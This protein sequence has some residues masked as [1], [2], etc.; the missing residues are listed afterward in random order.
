MASSKK[1]SRIHG[2]IRDFEENFEEFLDLEAQAKNVAGDIEIVEPRRQ[3]LRTVVGY[4]N[5]QT[6]P[7]DD[8]SVH[9]FDRGHRGSNHNISEKTI[10]RDRRQ[11]TYTLVGYDPLQNES[12]VADDKNRKPSN[13]QD[14]V[15]MSSG[16]DRKT[17][18]SNRRLSNVIPFHNGHEC[19]YIVDDDDDNSRNKTPVD[20]DF[21]RDDMNMLKDDKE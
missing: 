5:T 9:S 8:K 16:S 19:D 14:V 11:S 2:V 6:K 12:K 10:S 3:S 21:E 4:E 20:Y 18:V 13:T 17:S 7:T 1:R 15:I